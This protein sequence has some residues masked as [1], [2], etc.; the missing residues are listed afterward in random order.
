M[1]LWGLTGGENNCNRG[2]LGVV[3]TVLWSNWKGIGRM[4]VSSVMGSLFVMG[5]LII[6]GWGF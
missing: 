5:I 1:S 4:G 3:L 2:V 6:I